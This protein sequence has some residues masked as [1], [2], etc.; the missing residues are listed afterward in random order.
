LNEYLKTPHLVN[1]LCLDSIRLGHIH[2][3][4]KFRPDLVFQRVIIP[5]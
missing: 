3:H 4:K 2:V 1:Q 5:I